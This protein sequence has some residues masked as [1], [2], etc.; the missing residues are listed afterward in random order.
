MTQYHSPYECEFL[1]RCT[2]NKPKDWI[3]YLPHL[4]LK[5]GELLRAKGIE[6]IADIPEDVAERCEHYRAEAANLLI[7]RRFKNRR[8]TQL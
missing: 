1:D 6:S 5:R 2:A 4:V 7:W 3:F 8:I